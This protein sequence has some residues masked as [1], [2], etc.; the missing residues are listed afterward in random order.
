MADIKEMLALLERER[1]A[2]LRLDSEQ[3]DA[4]AHDKIALADRMLKSGLEPSPTDSLRLVQ[5][6]RRNHSLLSFAQHCLQTRTPRGVGV[7][8]FAK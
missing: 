6:L 1:Q 8:L 7:G 3:I 2:I 4:A 5:E